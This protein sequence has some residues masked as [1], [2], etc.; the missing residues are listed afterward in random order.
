MSDIEKT[1]PET[2]TVGIPFLAWTGR[3]ALE[4]A[5]K[6]RASLVGASLDG[7]SLDGASLVGASLVGAPGIPP[8]PDVKK[9]RSDKP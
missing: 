3:A 6:D 4:I 8:G 9:I 1:A 5:V 7:A 2:V